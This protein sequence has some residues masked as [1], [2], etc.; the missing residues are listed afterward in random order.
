MKYDAIIPSE[1]TPLTADVN[2]VPFK[3]KGVL[4]QASAYVLIFFSVFVA[5]YSCRGKY[6]IEQNKLTEGSPPDDSLQMT[7]HDNNFKFK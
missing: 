6:S 5:V 2:N 3:K 1:E 4:L 7:I